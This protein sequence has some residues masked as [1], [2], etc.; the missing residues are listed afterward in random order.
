M[1]R[2]LFFFVMQVVA[3]FGVTTTGLW[4]LF[5]PRHLQQFVHDNFALLP[6]AT[7]T[8]WLTP[9]LLR[10]TGL[11]ALWYGAALIVAVHQEL[12]ALRL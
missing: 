7:D 4:A 5:R 6:E 12:S 11:F 2:G 3:G 8:A 9:L 1:S 10:S